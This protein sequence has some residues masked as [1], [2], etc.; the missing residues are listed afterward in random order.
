MSD[1]EPEA[2]NFLAKIANSLA[3]GLLWLL[4]N[5]TV[6]IGFNFAFFENKPSLGN[7]IFY[8]WFLV[9]LTLL[10]FYYRKK[11]KL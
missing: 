9:S 6:G 3:V 11:W 7:F 1:M 4:I 5:C 8:V 2:R 10:I